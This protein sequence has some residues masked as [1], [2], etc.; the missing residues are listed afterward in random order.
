MQ[1]AGER[2]RQTRWLTADATLG[3]RNTIPPPDF[4][5]GGIDIT[6]A[7]SGSGRDDAVVLQ[8]DRPGHA[9]VGVADGDAVRLRPE[10][11]RRLPVE[12][13]DAAE[14]C[15]RGDVDQH[16]SGTVSSG[17]DT[18]TLNISGSANWGG[19]LDFYLCGPGVTACDVHGV[20]V[21][22]ST[23]SSADASHAY[24]SGSATL[25]SAGSYCWHADFTPNA[26][27]SAAG[28]KA[29]DDNG[30]NECFTVSPVTPTLTTNATCSAS[31]CVDWQHAAQRHR[32]RS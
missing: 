21:S 29:A 9:L 12:S 15:L 30:T 23:V 4:F 28:I 1:P 3:R 5:E 18:A 8:D 25:T 24:T 2:Q 7:F 32:R 10:P 19:T 20:E 17:T 22:T 11:D 26:A 6:Q 13:V 27:S 16:G 31:P 14:R